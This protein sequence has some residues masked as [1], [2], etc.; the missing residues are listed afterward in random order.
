MGIKFSLVIVWV[1]CLFEVR[2]KQ[3][4]EHRGSQIRM[5]SFDYAGLA[6]RPCRRD[7]NAA[8]PALADS[9][10]RRHRTFRL[11]QGDEQEGGV[12]RGAGLDQIGKPA[13]L[14]G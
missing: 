2:G 4:R 6:R 10:D 3:G 7:V 8:K 13:A 12:E 5:V 11:R 14:P 1:R 9:A